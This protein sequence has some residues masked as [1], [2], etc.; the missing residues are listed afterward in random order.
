VFG[1]VG[2]REIVLLVLVVMLLLGTRRIPEIGRSL[3][4]GLREFKEGVSVR[5]GPRLPR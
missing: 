4:R 2:I 5:A 3:G 1:S